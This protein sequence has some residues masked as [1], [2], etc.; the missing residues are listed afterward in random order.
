MTRILNDQPAPQKRLRLRWRLG[1]IKGYFYRVCWAFHRFL[2]GPK[3][4][5]GAGLSVQGRLRTRGGGTIVLGSDVI[6]ADHT[7]LYTH[8]KEATIR[9]GSGTFLNGTRI[10]SQTEVTIGESCI[11]ADAR[12]MDTDFH[13][14]SK[15]RWNPKAPIKTSPV[16][17][18][19]NVWIAAGAAVL[20]GVHI[21]ND[22][23]IGFG[24]VV[25]A[26]VPQGVIAAGNPTKVISEL[27]V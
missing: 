3:V 27:P 8:S 22:S 20:R 4:T 26:S 10:S 6:I 2:G 19:S 12:I 24:S 21:G 11:L 14:L 7:D 17:I 16:Q 1:C 9:I 23:V 25:S 5:A 15:D 18:G 13:S